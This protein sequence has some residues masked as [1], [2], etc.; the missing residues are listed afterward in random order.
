MTNTAIQSTPLLQKAYT[1]DG[2][3]ASLT[4]A[5]SNATNFTYDGLDR[6]LVTT[7]PDSSLD[8]ETLSYDADSNVLSR[9]TRK[10]DT[11]SFAY[12]TLNRVCTKAIATSATPCATSSANSTVFYAY[13]LAGRPT[14]VSDNS[15]SLTVPTGTGASYT[16]S[17]SYDALNRP[18]NVSWTTIVAQTTPSAASVT[19]GHGYDGNN[20]RIT[21]TANDN[22][23]WSYPTT[24]NVT[25]IPNALNQYS[26]VGAVTPTYD[27]NGNLT[28]DG[29]YTYGYDAENRLT[30]VT[31]GG[32]TVA[33]YAYD[34]QGRRKSK[35]V[36]TTTTLFVTDAD[37]RE[38]LEYDG[39]SGATQRWYAYGQGSNDVLN[40]MNV[41]AGTRET[42]IPDIQ[43]SI[44]AALDSGGTLTKTGYQSYGES[45]TAIGT[46]RYAAMRIDPETSGL[47]YDRARMYSPTWGRFLQPDPIGY[48]GG[49]NLYAYAN[50]D[51]IDFVDLLEKMP[52]LRPSAIKLTSLFRFIL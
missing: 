31:Q 11:I 12:D 52:M 19:F 43:G 20:R 28:Y 14:G 10:G 8:K 36:G 16:T 30:S 21:Q 9:V 46:F 47:Y 50:N 17:T 35:T 49:A 2:L 22:S 4:D 32:T 48:A 37:N 1:P 13:D 39:T 26:K 44:L 33:T 15:A 3:L 23:W 34:S 25:Y 38:V 5:N 45:P 29:T 42:M 51:P 40:Q 7:Y 6:L 18:T 41:A 24:S 27:G